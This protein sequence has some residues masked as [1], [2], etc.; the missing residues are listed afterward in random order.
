MILGFLIDVSPSSVSVMVSRHV[1][2]FVD[3]S[4]G[5]D[6]EGVCSSVGLGSGD[7][8]TSEVSG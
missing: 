2:H 3:S 7:A 4:V 5:V 6:P 8:G 1:V